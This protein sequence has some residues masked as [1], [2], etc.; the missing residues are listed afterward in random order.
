[1]TCGC[2]MDAMDKTSADGRLT[3]ECAVF[4]LMGVSDYILEAELSLARPIARR[5]RTGQQDDLRQALVR[6][7]DIASA[8]PESPLKTWVA[9]LYNRASRCLH[10][11]RAAADSGHFEH[12]RLPRI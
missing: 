2:K 3:A 8:L 5:L 7:E 6:I 9:L 10:Q 11:V 4:E 12:I 1:M